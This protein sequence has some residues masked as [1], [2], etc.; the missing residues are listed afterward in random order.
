MAEETLFMDP[1]PARV[2]GDHAISSVADRKR[3][4]GELLTALKLDDGQNGERRLAIMLALTDYE[5]PNPFS[6][7]QKAGL[8]FAAGAGTAQLFAYG[9]EHLG[10]HAPGGKVDREARDYVFPVLIEVGLLERAMVYSKAEF[11]AS[12]EPIFYG[13]HLKPKSPNSAYVLAEDVERLVMLTP[14]AEWPE[15][16]DEW[17]ADDEHRRVHLRRATATRAVQAAPTTNKHSTLIKE[18][19]EALL[20][21]V[22]AD[23]ELGFIDDADGDRLRGEWRE[24]L[25]PLGLIPD[26]ASRWAD[27]MLIN[28]SARK[29]WIVDA[30]TSDGEVD[31]VRAADFRKWASERGWSIAGMTTAYETW[32]RAA[33]RQGAHFNLALGS[34]IW[35]AEDGGKLIGPIESLSG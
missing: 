7:L 19:A 23:Y 9:V 22:A 33:A 17:L 6:L 32:S 12:G 25:E 10:L 1:Y 14:E 21:S 18:C 34:T 11:K 31:E 13:A 24:I 20:D 3:R 29:L 30:V 27:A 2:Q 8:P 28:E 35:I 15:A 5:T 26:L 4:L 16:R